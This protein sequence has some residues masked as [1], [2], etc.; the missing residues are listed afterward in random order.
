MSYRRRSSQL[1]GIAAAT[2]LIAAPAH[3]D[4]VGTGSLSW[5][6]AAVY[7]SAANAKTYLGYVTAPLGQGPS[8]NGTA[9]PS[10]GATGDTVTPSSPRG[11]DTRYTFT[12]TGATGT[13][14][15][16]TGAGSV[17]LKGTVTFTSA[18]HGFT[19]TVENPLVVLNGQTGTLAASGRKGQGATY[20]RSAPVFDLDLSKATTTD[21]TDGSRTIGG[22][23]PAINT[24]PFGGY[25]KGSGPDRTPNTFGGFALTIGAPAAAPPPPATTTPTNTTPQAVV[26]APKLD[27]APARARVR[28]ADRGATVVLLLSRDVAGS[29]TRSYAV[30]LRSRGRTIA[31]GTLHKRVLTLRVRRASKRYPRIRGGFTL[32]PASSKAKMGTIHLTVR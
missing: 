19:V 2:L 12:Y 29:A 21:N 26:T 22:I 10:A 31:A 1:A 23:V 6:M 9:T 13:Y 7:D 4:T 32:A 14:D 17:E 27:K 5:T 24:D 16:A 20:D 11:V 18:T 30:K 25:P 8:T 15:R 3:A 28:G